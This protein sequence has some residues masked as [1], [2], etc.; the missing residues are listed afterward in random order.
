MTFLGMVMG[1]VGTALPARTERASL[2]SI[3]VCSNR[4]LLWGIVFELAL[5]ALIIYAS[6][7]QELA[8]GR[9]Q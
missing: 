3:G 1:Q 6:P 8:G 5:S 2:R 4:L 9:R 7:L